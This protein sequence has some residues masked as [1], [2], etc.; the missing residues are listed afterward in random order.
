MS[1]VITR[2]IEEVGRRHRDHPH[3]R[4][5]GRAHPR[6]GVLEDRSSTR[7][8]TEQAGC[9]EKDGGVRFAEILVDGRPDDREC[10]LEPELGEHRVDQR[11]G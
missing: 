10:A 7:A 4:G 2:L 9:G 5:A 6:Q 8:D 3:P 11:R 1:L